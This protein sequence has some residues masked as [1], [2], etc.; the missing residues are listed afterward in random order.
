MDFDFGDIKK[1]YLKLVTNI[2]YMN[3]RRVQKSFRNKYI[4]KDYL[5]KDEQQIKEIMN[6][7]YSEHLKESRSEVA[8]F[9]N[10]NENKNLDLKIML[11]LYYYYLNPFDPNRIKMDEVN[12]EVNEILTNLSMGIEYP[13]LL[14]DNSPNSIT[15]P[16]DVTNL[17]NKS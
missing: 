11:R 2:Y 9:F 16:R 15:G 7:L 3:M 13:V 12:Q 1:N 5:F 14:Y 17:F 6:K 8:N 4:D 10:I